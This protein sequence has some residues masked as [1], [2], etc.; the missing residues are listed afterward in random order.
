MPYIEQHKRD[1]LDPLVNKI[2]KVLENLD[3]DY[4]TSNNT[5]NNLHYLLTKLMRR[6]YGSSSVE[7]TESMGV[8]ERTKL[9]HYEY[10]SNN[11]LHQQQY[12]N[13]DVD[14]EHL[15]KPHKKRIRYEDD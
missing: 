3:C 12:D 15:I 5:E 10:M 1:Q 14:N 4:D 7:L 9:L 2:S 6:L 13:G 11:V 8:L